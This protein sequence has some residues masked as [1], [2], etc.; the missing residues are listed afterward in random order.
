L[1]SEWHW[2]QLTGAQNQR[3]GNSLRDCIKPKQTHPAAA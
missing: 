1:M 3:N 2:T